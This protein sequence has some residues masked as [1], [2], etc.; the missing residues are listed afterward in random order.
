MAALEVIGSP[1]SKGQLEAKGKGILER[2]RFLAPFISQVVNPWS[3]RGGV[4]EGEKERRTSR[5]GT[6]P[7][8]QKA[9]GEPS[10]WSHYQNLQSS[11]RLKAKDRTK[12]K[13]T[14][15]TDDP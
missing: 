6:R 8:M 5:K 9:M 12:V 13:Q 2:G 1:G 4:G 11:L 3:R 14:R 10:V 15:G 7:F